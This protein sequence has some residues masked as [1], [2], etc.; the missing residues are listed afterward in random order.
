MLLTVQKI[1]LAGLTPSLVAAAAGGDS[2]AND[3]TTYIQVDNGGGSSINV[4]VSSQARAPEGTAQA[5]NVVAVPAAGSRLIGPFTKNAWNDAS[6]II[7][8]TYSAVTTVTV[9]AISLPA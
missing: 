2:F 7:S 4:T 8:L 5:D 9:G 6:G 1:V 3:G